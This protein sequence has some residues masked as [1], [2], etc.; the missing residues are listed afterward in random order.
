MEEGKSIQKTQKEKKAVDLF[1]QM[2]KNFNDLYDGKGSFMEYA[3]TKEEVVIKIK[4]DIF[5]IIFGSGYQENL[6]KNIKKSPK[7]IYN[8]FIY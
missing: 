5:S 4:D 6:K 8:F 1:H 3:K 7:S 2:S